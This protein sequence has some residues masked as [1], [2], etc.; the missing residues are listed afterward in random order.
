M[1]NQAKN[2]FTSSVDLNIVAAAIEL[3][4]QVRSAAVADIVEL[5]NEGVSNKGGNKVH[6]T[7]DGVVMKAPSLEA[8][9]QGFIKF[10]RNQRA[11]KILELGF[12]PATLIGAVDVVVGGKLKQRTYQV[13]NVQGWTVGFIEIVDKVLLASLTAAEV[14]RYFPGYATDNKVASKPAAG[15]KPIAKPVVKPSTK[16]GAPA[17]AAGSPAAAKKPTS[18]AKPADKKAPAKPADKKA[19]AN[20]AAAPAPQADKKAAPETK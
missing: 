8:L 18:Q 4:K 20:P 15:Q 14:K 16:P 10:G 2:A 17:I 13:C 12:T 1:K 3:R 11:R 19:P 5:A 7:V 6:V 9:K